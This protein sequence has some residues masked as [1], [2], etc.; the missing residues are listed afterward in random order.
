MKSI[1][2]LLVAD[3]TDRPA[4]ADNV[5]ASSR[6]LCCVSRYDDSRVSANLPTS[7]Q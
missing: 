3:T 6:S 5:S 2:E 1:C 4:N 7:G